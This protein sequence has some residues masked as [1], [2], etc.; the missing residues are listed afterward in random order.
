MIENEEYEKILK[1]TQNLGRTQF[2]KLIYEKQKRIKELEDINEDHRK[3]NAELNQKLKELEGSNNE[4]KDV[5]DVRIKDELID[6][7]G[8]LKN[9]LDFTP[10]DNEQKICFCIEMLGTA[11]NQLIKNQK[12]LKEKLEERN[13][14]N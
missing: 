11:I 6:G 13:E 14:K 8:I 9:W 2:V 10:N 1:D 12:Y 4:W 3:L 5:E 7:Y